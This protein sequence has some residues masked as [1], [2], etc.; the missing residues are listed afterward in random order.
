[1][2]GRDRNLVILLPVELYDL[3]IESI[4]PY[5]EEV[6]AAAAPERTAA[7]GRHTV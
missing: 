5:V 6:E 1:M 4:Q 3:I 7:E 2:I